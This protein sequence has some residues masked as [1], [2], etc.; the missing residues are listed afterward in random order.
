M[1]AEKERLPGC[2]VEM[3]AIGIG[4][5]CLLG[6]HATGNWQLFSVRVIQVIIFHSIPSSEPH[7]GLHPLQFLGPA[8]V[9]KLIKVIMAGKWLEKADANWGANPGSLWPKSGTHT[10]HGANPFSR[11][12]SCHKIFHDNQL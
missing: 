9:N 3:I 4:F 8:A 1:A 2:Q 10:G 5:I 11:L 6:T 7:T 12:G